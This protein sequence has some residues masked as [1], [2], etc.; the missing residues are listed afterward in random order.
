MLREKAVRARG[1]K[2]ENF[3]RVAAFNK[4]QMRV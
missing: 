3:S 1:K 4:N 2:G